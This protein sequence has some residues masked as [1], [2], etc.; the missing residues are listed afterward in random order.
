MGKAMEDLS[1]KKVI[2]AFL[3]VFV[4][5]SSCSFVTF[6]DGEYNFTYTTNGTNATITGVENLPDGLRNLLFRKKSATAMWL[7]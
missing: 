7:P 3:A 5:A 2:A 1:M 4:L 6:A